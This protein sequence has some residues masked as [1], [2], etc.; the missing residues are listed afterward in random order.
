M[1]SDAIFGL[2]SA[3]TDHSIIFATGSTGALGS[4]ALVA[5]T[6]GQSSP[7]GTGNYLGTTFLAKAVDQLYAANLTPIHEKLAAVSTSS[8]IASPSVENDPNSASSS[9][10]FFVTSIPTETSNTAAPSTDLSTSQN[11]GAVAIQARSLVDTSSFS[12]PTFAPAVAAVV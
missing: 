1:S 9:K 11:N 8:S 6:N 3:Q 12:W 2:P 5:A 10:I 4:D 7:S